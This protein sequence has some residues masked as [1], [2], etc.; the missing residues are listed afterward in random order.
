M[1]YFLCTVFYIK[2]V[3]YLLTKYLKKVNMKTRSLE[4][5]KNCSALIPLISSKMWIKTGDVTPVV[6]IY[7][8]TRLYW[9]LISHKLVSGLHENLSRIN[10][11]PQLARETH[12]YRFLWGQ[13]AW[14]Y[15][16]TN[17]DERDTICILL[18]VLRMILCDVF[19]TVINGSILF[20]YVP[21]QI[22]D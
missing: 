17:V 14:R 1:Y 5:K 9:C 10:A 22:M 8:I 2:F 6:S 15:I 4:S 3:S 13:I 16:I 7:Q 12:L 21:Q 18:I 11:E 19:Y 20:R